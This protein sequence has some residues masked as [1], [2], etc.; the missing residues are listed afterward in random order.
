MKLQELAQKLELKLVT[1]AFDKEVGGVYISDMVSDVIASAKAGDLL[2]TVQIHSN[3]V[4]AANLL[5]LCGILVTQGKLPTDDVVK[6]ARTHLQDHR[7]GRTLH[8][9]PQQ[10][11]A[12]RM[13][14]EADGSIAH[15]DHCP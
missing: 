6:I 15:W 12:R 4:A 10:F 3:V 1:A 13:I 8:Q 7:H 11:F 5:D 14:A 2:V 9:P